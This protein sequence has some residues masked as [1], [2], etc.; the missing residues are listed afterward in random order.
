MTWWR[1]LLDSPVQIGIVAGL[2][3]A[4]VV[5]PSVLVGW[6][7]RGWWIAKRPDGPLIT[8]IKQLEEERDKSEAWA[9][10]A[11]AHETAIVGYAIGAARRLQSMA[12]QREGT[13]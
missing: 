13:A 10:K 7:L 11:V 6:S 5:A 4:I 1:M 12:E 2:A 3:G 9:N 8:R